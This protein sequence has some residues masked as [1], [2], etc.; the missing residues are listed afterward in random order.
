[1]LLIIGF[2]DQGFGKNISF[3]VMNDL[4]FT[5]QQ[6]AWTTVMSFLFGFGSKLAFGWLFDKYSFKGITI[7]YL[8]IVGSIAMAFGVEGIITL[9]IFQMARGFSQSGILVETPIFAKH[10]FGPNH[11]GKMIGFFSATSAVGLAIGPQLPKSHPRQNEVQISEPSGQ[12]ALS[13]I[14]CTSSSQSR[15]R[16]IIIPPERAI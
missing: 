8:L 6:L 15:S 3:Y 10:S 11:L 12:M 13:L 2:V 4:G 16:S 14:F 5:R 9:Y 1:V 7:C